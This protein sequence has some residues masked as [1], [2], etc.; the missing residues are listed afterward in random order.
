[1]INKYEPREQSGRDTFGRYRSQIRSTAICAL[2]ILESKEVD[3][4]Y[5]DLHDD[6]VV[7]NKTDGGH[8]YIFIQV[9]T[10]S[11]QNHNWSTNDL[12]N[13]PVKAKD[14]N[15][16]LSKIKDSFLGKLL[17]HTIVFDDT[18]LKVIFQTNINNNDAVNEFEEDL[19]DG[20]FDNKYSKFLL[21]EFNKIFLDNDEVGFE[22]NEIREK[23]SKLNFETDV[24][25]LKNDDESFEPLAR[26]KI[27]KYSEVDLQHEESRQIL[28]NL[29]E[30]ISKKTEGVI[31]AWTPENI[32][33]MASIS[34]DDLLD[35]LSLSKDAYYRLLEGES[36]N[37]IKQV[38]II[39][40]LLKNTS[41][42]DSVVKICSD[43]KINWDIWLRQKRHEIKVLDIELLIDTIRQ[44]ISISTT[45][46]SFAFK[47]LKSIAEA[48]LDELRKEDLIYDLDIELI[49]GGI[50]SEFVRGK[51][52]S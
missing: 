22:E 19:K 3:R 12:L 46:T 18:C 48:I 24:Q 47:D 31:K 20:K 44:N 9:K 21:E 51:A 10:K 32:E 30:L 11:K 26:D 50:L 17:L 25:H 43:L 15:K 37:A 27:Y 8:V 45:G 38:S 1:M 35:V 29:L 33:K 34:I 52:W 28:I 2:K 41:A 13:M 4:I 16:S 49:I 7:R 14:F 39:Q 40:R 42:N 36:N 23:L 6:I 5:C